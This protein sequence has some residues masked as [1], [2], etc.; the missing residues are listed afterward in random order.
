VRPFKGEVTSAEL[1]GR[2]RIDDLFL[3]P[4]IDCG[5]DYNVR[6]ENKHA[7]LRI[8][9]WSALS[10]LHT[11]LDRLSGLGDPI[12][13]GLTALVSLLLIKAVAFKGKT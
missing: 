11:H 3:E 9:T 4:N 5:S 7:M 10:G 6:S 1:F 12:G 8:R 13:N 2:G